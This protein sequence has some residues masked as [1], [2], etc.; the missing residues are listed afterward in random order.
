MN[1]YIKSKTSH[2]YAAIQATR[3]Q[4]LKVYPDCVF[5]RATRTLRELAQRGSIPTLRI[6]DKKQLGYL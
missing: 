3:A 1:V 2:D 5:V 6:I 4:V